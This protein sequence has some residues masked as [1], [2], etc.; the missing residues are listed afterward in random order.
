MDII[1]IFTKAPDGNIDIMPLNYKDFQ[2]NGEGYKLVYLGKSM[3]L[4]N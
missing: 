1:P 3:E 4:E 2:P